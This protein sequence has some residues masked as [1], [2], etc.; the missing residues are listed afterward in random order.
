[1]IQHIG[2]QCAQFFTEE[3][4]R[5]TIGNCQTN[6]S[7]K[8]Q[9]KLVLKLILSHTVQHWN[10]IKVAIFSET[11]S[12]TDIG[13]LSIGTRLFKNSTFQNFTRA[14]YAQIFRED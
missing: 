10:I 7:A 4:L 2:P 3:R 13:F 1:M 6:A 9:I 12:I 8:S 11:V 5:R 14:T